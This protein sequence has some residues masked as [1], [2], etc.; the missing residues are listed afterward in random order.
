MNS[1]LKRWIAR[2]LLAA[3]AFAHASLAFSACQLERSALSQAMGSADAAAVHRE[4]ETTMVMDWTKYPNRCFAH[5][6]ADLQTVGAAI[7]LVRS[8]SGDPVLSLPRDEPRAVAH[9]GLAASPPGTPPAR[10]LFHSFL[11]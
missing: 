6:T 2:L 1:L 8:P 3:V 10:I 7:A 5:C 9:T 11:I 4:C